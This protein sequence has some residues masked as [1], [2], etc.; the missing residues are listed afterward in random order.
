MMPGTSTPALGGGSGSP[1]K[2]GFLVWES[3][4]RANA[5]TPVLTFYGFPFFPYKLAVSSR[6]GGW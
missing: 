6:L 2:F 5:G 1:R 4:A 3:G